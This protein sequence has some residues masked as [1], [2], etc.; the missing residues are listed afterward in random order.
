MSE[1]TS[2][3]VEPTSEALRAFMAA[4]RQGPVVMLNLLR[5]RETADYSGSPELAPPAAMSG[6]DA[7]KRYMVHT[8][9]FLAK[10]G[11]EA[12]F[13][14]DGGGALIG[15][16]DERWD[17]VLLMRYPSTEAFFKFAMDPEYQ[18]GVGH[19][20]AALADSRLVPMTARTTPSA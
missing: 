8:T 2:G 14:G 10:I 19:R 18:K 7:Y 17:M 16:S 9:P 3:F 4:G 11:G 20:T 5:F 12:V 13:L 1:S 6:A 15:P